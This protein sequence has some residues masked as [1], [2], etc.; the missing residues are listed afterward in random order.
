LNAW[1]LAAGAAVVLS[2]GGRLTALDGGPVDLTIGHLIASNG[3]VHD[4]LQAL[5]TGTDIT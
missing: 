1:D 2:A 5:I 3:R 4:A